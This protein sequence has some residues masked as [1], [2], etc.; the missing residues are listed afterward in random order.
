MKYIVE[1]LMVTISGVGPVQ[2]GG[3]GS[4]CPCANNWKCHTK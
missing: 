1:P 3:P 2:M 4:G